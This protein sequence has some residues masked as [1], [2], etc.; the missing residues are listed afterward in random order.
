LGGQLWNQCLNSLEQELSGRD[1]YTWIRPLHAIEEGKTLRLLAPNRFVLESVQQNFEQRIHDLLLHLK[2]KN[3]PEIILQIGSVKKTETTADT[4]PKKTV[5]PPKKAKKSFSKAA[6]QPEQKTLLDTADE[7]E[8]FLNQ[9]LT[10]DSFILGQSNQLARSAS[11]QVAENGGYNPLFIYGGV[12]LGKTHL[13]HAVGNHL[14]SHHGQNK[15]LY[16]RA[17]R[18]VNDMIKALQEKKM[19]QFKT[20]YRSLDA[21]LID[22]VQFFAKKVQSQEELFHTFNVL[23]EGKKNIILTCDRPPH[24][25]NDF[26]ERLKSRLGWGLAV[27]V[28]PPD[29]DTRLAILTAK[30]LQSGI[31]IPMDVL[32]F[33][34]AQIESNVRELEGALHRLVAMARF[35][36]ES[37]TLESAQAALNDLVTIK[38]KEYR[39]ITLS[40]IQQEVADYYQIPVTALCSR[41][42]HRLIARPRQIAMALSK[43]LTQHSLPEIGSAFGG[44]DHTTV[45]HSCRTVTKLK[46]DDTKINQDYLN[47]LKRLS[48]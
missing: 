40:S 21:L 13:M 30:T 32:N 44:R 5:A 35:L 17:E 47:L 25:L 11:L 46:V 27:G 31:K 22:D 14:V 4:S 18:F 38:K 41:Q 24:Q 12:G 28:N 29:F 34:A 16:V 3:P 9:D 19:G 37:I 39:A 33:I 26:D 36:H 15:V 20:F 8:H 42:R 10:F 7:H 45:L 48:V 43:E 6:A 1:F 23:L 2:P